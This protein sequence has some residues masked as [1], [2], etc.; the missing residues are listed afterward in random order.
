MDDIN[1]IPDKK[2]DSKISLL[3]DINSLNVEDSKKVQE[4]LN[5]LVSK[6]IPID[7]VIQD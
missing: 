3:K 1:L 6:Q 4:L 5:F 2:V 7:K